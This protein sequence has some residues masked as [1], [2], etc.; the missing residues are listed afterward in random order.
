MKPFIS[1]ISCLDYAR[2]GINQ[3]VRD[4]FL[5]NISDVDYKFF[6]GDGTKVQESEK[7][8]FSWEKRGSRYTDKPTDVEYI[9]YTPQ[10]DE[11]IVPVPDDYK[12]ISFKTRES[13]RWALNQGYDFLFQ[14]YSDVLIDVERLLQSGYE[15]MKYCG[16]ENG[17]GY[18][19][20]RDSLEITANSE[21]TSWNDD[22][23]VRDMLGNHGIDL[24]VDPRYGAFPTLPKPNNNV[25]TSHLCISPEVYTADKMLTSYKQS[26][27]I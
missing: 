2:N 17:G 11:I 10:F 23:W 22:G 21:V 4:T 20:N 1:I 16:G 8:K 13:H 24:V 25:I 9:S 12:H 6:L 19:L 14:S 7:F 18:W 3:A 15:S 26:K 27:E 5:S